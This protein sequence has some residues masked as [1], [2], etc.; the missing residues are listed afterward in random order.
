MHM[1]KFFPSFPHN[2]RRRLLRDIIAVILFTS[3]LIIG[4]SSYLAV[5]LRSDISSALIS[6]T[7][8][9][10][11]KRFQ[12]FIEPIIATLQIGHGWG[13]ERLLADLS[14]DELARLFIPVLKT[15]AQI[16]GVVL[17]TETGR[18]HFLQRRQEGWQ[19]RH[20]N[21]AKED[22]ADYCLWPANGGD[23]QKWKDKLHYDSRQRPWFTKAMASPGQLIW[24]EPYRFQSS[25]KIGVT[26]AI[27]WQSEKNG[28]Q[29]LALDLLLDDLLAFL[30]SLDI[31]RNSHIALLENDGSVI[32]HNDRHGD[33][34]AAALGRAV[35]Q[36]RGVGQALNF[37]L[38][39]GAWWAGFSPL[40][41]KTASAWIAVMVPE[42]EVAHGVGQRWRQWA[43]VA[44]L[45]LATGILLAYRLV[46]RYSYQLRDLPRQNISTDNAD[47][48]LYR[49][50]SAGES[51]T[52]EFKSTMRTNLKTGKTGKEIE[53][54]WIKAV[55]AFMNSDGGILLIGVND[56]GNIIG[57]RADNFE[58]ED[59]LRLHF[60][61]LIS[62]H[63]GPEF[64]RF[65]HLKIRRLDGE[66]VLIVECER[67]RKPVFLKV[68][69]NEEFVVRSG[70]SSLKM[71]MS[72]M[73]HYLE[74]RI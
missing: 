55:V 43:M 20:L 39:Q 53:L 4:F 62:H 58:N 68:G 19:L 35:E 36:W 44:L 30:D 65:V 69:K 40:G 23:P 54:A 8:T 48:D 70:P 52:L 37:S 6:E 59:R 24:T 42:E 26:A 27:A 28:Q 38:D 46:V 14:G 50:I 57:V 63:I 7:T 61:S 3:L 25:K 41:G 22:Q 12:L 73:V 2:I 56:E 71:T 47:D 72:Q 33:K 17:A 32:L 31:G 66:M 60:K 13:E 15:Y 18:E 9:V 49:L 11:K 34:G 1:H 74:D 64:A 29:V 67:V 10:V 16:S 21:N 5:N 45:V 51:A